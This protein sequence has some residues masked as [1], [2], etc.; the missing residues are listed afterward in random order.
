MISKTSLFTVKFEVKYSRLHELLVNSVNCYQL[1]SINAD[2]FNQFDV[3]IIS[4]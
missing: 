2:F 3:F 4:I 1:K